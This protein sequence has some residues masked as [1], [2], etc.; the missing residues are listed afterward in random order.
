MADAPPLD[1]YR[2]MTTDDLTMLHQA[3][4]IDRRQP[5]L[6]AEGHA[7]GEARMA[8]IRTVL[9]ERGVQFATDHHE[10]PTR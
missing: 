5:H 9:S 10:P 4:E 3:F 2:S 8:A 1:L 6:T 7:F